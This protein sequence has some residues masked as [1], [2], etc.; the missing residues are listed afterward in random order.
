M[1]PRSVDAL[2][3][4][5]FGRKGGKGAGRGSNPSLVLRTPRRYHKAGRGPIMNPNDI[6]PAEPDRRPRFIVDAN[7][8]RLATW[9]RVLGFDASFPPA[10]PDPELLR[11]AA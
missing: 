8:G 9:L 7:C 3:S 2:P 6:V 1:E 11:R 5:P 4:P 10:L